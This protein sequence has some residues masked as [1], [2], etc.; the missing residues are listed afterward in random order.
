MFSK[1]LARWGAEYSVRIISPARKYESNTER[2][3]VPRHFNLL[4]WAGLSCCAKD[5]CFFFPRASKQCL[6]GSAESATHRWVILLQT[7]KPSLQTLFNSGIKTL[8]T[9]GLSHFWVE[10]AHHAL[11][12]GGFVIWTNDYELGNWLTDYQIHF[13]MWLKSRCFQMIRILH[14]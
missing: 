7:F 11:L 5:C 1:L 10:T 3:I 12:P 14:F 13:Q 2:D 4:L 6:Q 8:P 9:Q